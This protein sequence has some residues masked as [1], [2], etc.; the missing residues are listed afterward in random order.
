MALRSDG[1]VV[2]WGSNDFG[3][4]NV[5]VWLTNVTAISGGDVHSLALRSDG[6][7]VAWGNNDYG[8]TNVPIWLTNVIAI[9]GGGN[10][11]LALCSDRTVVAWGS[12]MAGETNVPAG[13]KNVTSI[14]GGNFY[15]LAVGSCV[16]LL[17]LSDYGN[18]FPVIGTNGLIKDLLVSC[19]MDTAVTMGSTQYLCVGWTGMGDVPAS[20][21]SN[22]VTFV[23]TN[24][25]S[26]AW[27]WQT[28]YWLDIKINGGGTVSTSSCWCISDSIVVLTATNVSGFTFLGWRGDTNGCVINGMEITVPVSGPRSI[29]ADFTGGNIAVT[30]TSLVFS[31]KMYSAIVPQTITITNTGDETL[32]YTIESYFWLSVSNT[33]GSLASGASTQHTV[34]VK[35]LGLGTGRHYGKM[36]ITDP[37]ATNTPQ[38]VEVILTLE[39]AATLTNPT[40]VVVWGN[41]DYGQTNVPVWLTNVTSIASGWYHSMALRTDG[42]VAAWGG[43]NYGQTN[44]PVWL[45]NVIAIAGAGHCSMALRSDGTVVAWGNNDYGQTNVPMWLT[46]VTSIASGWYHSMA[47]RTD[48]TVVAWGGNTYGQTNVPMWLSNVTAIAGGANHSLAL[49]SDGTVVAWGQST[50]GQTNVPMW[51]SNA[52]SV[53]GGG[54]HSVALRSDGTVVAWGKSFNGQ[55]NVPAGLTNVISIVGGDS[56]SLALR[57]DG[58]VVTWGQ[59]YNGFGYV[60]MYIP[61]W[62]T[63]AIIIGGE[64]NH[65]VAICQRFN[66]EV[67]PSAHGIPVPGVGTS[68]FIKDFSVACSVASVTISTTQY[69]CKGWTGTGSVPGNGMSNSVTFAITNDSSIAWLWQTNYW[70]DTSTCGAGTVDVVSAW[71]EQGSNLVITASPLPGYSFLDWEGETNGCMIMGTEI[72]VPMTEPRRI[73]AL[74]NGPVIGVGPVSLMFTG[75]VNEAN[76]DT[77]MITIT[78][79]GDG[80]LN[81]TIRSYFWLSVSNAS[82]SLASGASTQHTVRVNTFGLGMGKYYGKVMIADQFATN[83]PQVVEVILTLDHAATPPTIVTC[84]GWNVAGQTNV[85]LWLTNAI[86]VAAGSYHSLALRS[87]GKVVAW[88]NNNHGQT[89]VPDGLINITAIAGGTYHSLALCSNGTVVAWGD[90]S[91]GTGYPPMYVPSWLTNVIAIA[92]GGS[93]ALAL[94]SDGTLVAWGYNYSGQTNVPIWLTNVTRIANGISHS[95]ALRSDGTVAAWGSNDYGQTN[96]PAGLSNVVDVAGGFKHSLALRSD[97]TV[98]AWGGNDYGQTNVPAGLSNVVDVAS[99]YNHSLVLRLDGTIMTW[100]GNDYGQTNVPAGLTNMTS[101]AAGWDHSLVVEQKVNL[102]V[103]SDQGSPSPSVGTY[104]LR[105]GSSQTCFVDA[106]AGIANT[107]YVSIGWAGI[108]SVP[109]SGT[110]NNVSFLITNNS[111]ITWLWQTNYWLQVQAGFGGT[112]DLESSWCKLGTNVN[113]TATPS[114]YFTFGWW[115]GDVP[116]AQT[117]NSSIN[118]VMDQARLAQANFAEILATNRTPQWW[119]ASYGWTNN[120]NSAAINDADLDGITNWQEYITGTDPTDTNSVF[121]IMRVD[122]LNGSN[123]LVWL[124]GNTNLP[125][126]GIYSSTNL[127]DAGSWVQIT[128]VLRSFNGTNVWYDTTVQ[129]SGVPRFYRVVATNWP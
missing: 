60:P 118:L 124:G 122:C 50:Y 125:P 96:V 129:T 28:N 88:G 26:I 33:S 6:T 128:N 95:L 43:N 120:F 23:I 67:F 65:A 85:P 7:V 37:F 62:L 117:N 74:F 49:C 81:Y 18:P 102:N 127:I 115:S 2:V 112:V 24:D 25:S 4:T 91:N 78:N 111:S 93:Y 46:N 68:E 86:D 13:L 109:D 108:G 57:S 39:H 116:A 41:N 48:G 16:E 22:N 5:P 54:S 89:N 63:S 34:S 8:Q 79:T 100:G 11:S 123:C 42:T 83:T 119:L 31:G 12:N 107:Q 121:K 32:N 113:L 72:T 114:N 40:V 69:Q 77:R 64:E 3:Q 52:V 98:V 103:V 27:L 56:H 15:S 44:V 51:L 36:T 97:G 14:A 38:V 47:L 110:S 9:A 58:S 94:R 19:A 105:K 53:A 80:T 76:T 71:Q 17:V 21:T 59:Y 82:G 92:S 106:V 70:L 104:I 84:W 30:P 126:F 66:L 20:G 99:G 35:T 45:T 75:R 10:H 55:T 90:Y 29:I 101:I 87:D 73:L 1:T 61:S